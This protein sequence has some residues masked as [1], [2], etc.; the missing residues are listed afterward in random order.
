MFSLKVVDV[1]KINANSMELSRDEN[2]ASAEH[3]NYFKVF[4]F[5]GFFRL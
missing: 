3:V 5:W 4:L 1:V 2:S